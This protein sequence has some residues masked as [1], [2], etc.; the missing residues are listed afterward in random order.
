VE[1]LAKTAGADVNAQD[2][3]SMSRS[4]GLFTV[5]WQEGDTPMHDICSINL[6]AEKLDIAISI[7]TILLEHGG[8]TKFENRVTS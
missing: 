2:A 6:S 3:V 7:I 5:W 1:Y 4:Y 8:D